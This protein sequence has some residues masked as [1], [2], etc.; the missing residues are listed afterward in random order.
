MES[1]AA[2]FKRRALEE[3]AAAARAVHPSAR[4]S[5]LGLAGR[6]EELAGALLDHHREVV[7]MANDGL[8]SFTPSR[9]P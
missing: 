6:Y 4:E 3:R 1:D 8:R 5:H 7:G 9:V 2:Y